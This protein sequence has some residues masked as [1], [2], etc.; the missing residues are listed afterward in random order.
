MKGICTECFLQMKPSN[1]IDRPTQCPFCKYSSYAVEYRGAKTQEEKSLEQAEEQK[2]IEAKKR[3]QSQD[4]DRVTLADR[5]SSDVEAQS[6]VPSFRAL[7]SRSGDARHIRDSEVSLAGEGMAVARSPVVNDGNGRHGELDLDLEDVM[8]TEAIWRSIQDLDPSCGPSGTT[9]PVSSAHGSNQCGPSSA[10][11]NQGEASSAESVTGGLAVAIA[12][13]AERNIQRSELLQLIRENNNQTGQAIDGAIAI[14]AFSGLEPSGAQ[15][16]DGCLGSSSSTTEDD[17]W[18][19]LAARILEEN[20]SLESGF[21][22]DE[23]LVMDGADN[24]SSS[25]SS[26]HSLSDPSGG[27]SDCSDDGAGA[28][29]SHPSAPFAVDRPL[30]TVSN[31]TA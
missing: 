1:A 21:A 26:V 23:D 5:I 4:V 15:S 28:S 3:M 2:V 16:E 8:I 29:C 17:S 11:I 6:A 14:G 10:F 30:I 9:E 18:G 31:A 27:S 7:S 22:S 20:P 19:S 13:M 25:S 12:R 24:E